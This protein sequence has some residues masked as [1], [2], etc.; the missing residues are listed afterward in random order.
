MAEICNT[1]LHC[2]FN[3]DINPLYSSPFIYLLV[4][5]TIFIWISFI[6]IQSANAALLY[7]TLGNKSRR[8]NNKYNVDVYLTIYRQNTESLINH[9]VPHLS[10]CPSFLVSIISGVIGEWKRPPPRRRH[11]SGCISTSLQKKD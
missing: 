10:I 2:I 1:K 3:M 4:C 6:T 11:R 8:R 7:I 5:T 9:Y